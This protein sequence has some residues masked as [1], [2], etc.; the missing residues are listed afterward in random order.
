MSSAAQSWLRLVL[1]GTALAAAAAGAGVLWPALPDLGGTEAAG[2]VLQQARRQGV[3]HVALR[4][5]ARP[6]LPGDP[7]PPEPDVYDQALADWLGRQL[8][9][10][11][12]IAPAS[13][14]DL[15]LEGMA[16]SGSISVEHVRNVL[17]RLNNP[18]TPEQAETSLR[19]SQVPVADTA[20]YDRLRPTH[21][22]GQEVGHA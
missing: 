11:V 15:V 20:R 9:T 22:D 6:S 19:L 18:A 7:L 14:A 13:D 2:P 17:A 4:S 12:Q 3:L 16:P 8:G 21:L 10:S 1:V 5:Y